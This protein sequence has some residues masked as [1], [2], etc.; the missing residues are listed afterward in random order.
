VRP[1]FLPAVLFAILSAACSSDDGPALGAD[2]MGDQDKEEVASAVGAALSRS[3]SSENGLARTSVD[4]ALGAPPAWMGEIDVGVH[5]GELLGLRIEVD[6]SCLDAAGEPMSACDSTSDGASVSADVDGEISLLGWTGSVSISLAWELRGLQSDEVAVD[7][8][9][10]IALGSEFLEWFRPVTHA[11][12]FTITAEY[13]ATLRRDDFT[14]ISG[15]ADL[16]IDYERTRSDDP[17]AGARFAFTVEA[18]VENG[19]AEL[20]IGGI[21]F[22]IDLLTGA[23]TRM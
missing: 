10:E 4:V 21:L 20:R 17:D 9:A 2:E 3:L 8:S 12:T 5:A 6:A 11:A 23:A 14:A 18:T 16:S 19:R 22:R 1:R 13:A 15:T 7:G